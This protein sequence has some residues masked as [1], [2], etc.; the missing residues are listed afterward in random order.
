MMNDNQQPQ[1]PQFAQQPA[2]QN[3]QPATAKPLPPAANDE[4]TQIAQLGYN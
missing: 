1:A 3:V 2:S 4:I